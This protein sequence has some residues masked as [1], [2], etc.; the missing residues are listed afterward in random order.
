M[1]QAKKVMFDAI[2][3]RMNW[4]LCRDNIYAIKNQIL[5]VAYLKE[6][7]PEIKTKFNVRSLQYICDVK[8]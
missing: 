8:V 2:Y 4:T 5:Q 7:V 3:E 1:L 6:D